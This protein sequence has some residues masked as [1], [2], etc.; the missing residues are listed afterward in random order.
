M[1]SSSKLC[2]LL[3]VTYLVGLLVSQGRAAPAKVHGVKLGIRTLLKIEQQ[4]IASLSDDDGPL[5]K[6]DKVDIY[7]QSGKKIA[8]AV[9]SEIQLGKPKDSFKFLSWTLPKGGKQK[10]AANTLLHIAT[11]DNIYDV[12][13]DPANKAFVLLDP[14]RR[15]ELARERLAKTGHELWEEPSQEEREETIEK[16]RELF[17][18]T[19]ELFP[20][21]QFHLQE[22]EFYLFFTDMPVEQVAGYVAN[23]DSMYRQLCLAF[24]ILPD[25]NIWKGK[26][27]ILAF[28]NADQ[29]HQFEAELMNY[30]DSAGTQGLYHGASDGRVVVAVFSGKDPAQFGAVLVH[31]TAHGFVHRLRSNVD[32]VGWINEGIAEWITGVVVPAS[33]V[34]ARRQSDAM[35]LLRTKHSMDGFFTPDKRLTSTDYG[36]ASSLTEFMLQT[37]PNLYRAF[38][39]A[40]K[41]GYS[42]EN[43]LKLTYDC[44]PAELVQS[45]GNSIG[46]PDLAP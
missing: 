10:M 17:K 20:D 18:K 40:I 45:F 27:P 12:V 32:I 34:V 35:V 30:P 9:I 43:A 5:K 22:T 26:C 31:E 33:N 2:G 21:R 38:L 7:L 46:V 3:V 19:Q 25:K 42:L 44:T 24:G 39:M 14:V 15:D 28:V 29:Y 23:L 11:E 16:A 8:D 37:D 1:K 41:D 6:G 4:Y 36:I 13:Q